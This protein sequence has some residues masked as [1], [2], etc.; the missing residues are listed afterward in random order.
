CHHLVND[1]AYSPDG[2]LLAVANGS[3][4]SVHDAPSGE[5]LFAFWAG[6]GFV[7]VCFAGRGRAVAASDLTGTVSIWDLALGRQVFKRVASG[8]MVTGLA[9]S[10]DGPLL[11]TGDSDS[12]VLL[13]KIPE[14]PPLKDPLSP[15]EL[16]EAWEQ[17]AWGSEKIDR[18]YGAAWRLG[19]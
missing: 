11:A 14:T 17:L 7:T 2:K 18:A 19:R 1:L 16:A 10:P 12:T 9:A 6:P 3:A 8:W 5:F 13:W 4:V 15:R